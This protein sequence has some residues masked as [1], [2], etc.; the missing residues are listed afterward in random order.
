MQNFNCTRL[1]NSE[2]SLSS[3]LFNVTVLNILHNIFQ[4]IMPVINENLSVQRVPIG[5]GTGGQF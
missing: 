5:L 2:F 1:T 3:C 4:A